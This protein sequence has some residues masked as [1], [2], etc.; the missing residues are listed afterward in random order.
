MNKNGGGEEE[1]AVQL[2]FNWGSPIGRSVSHTMGWTL[3]KTFVVTMKMSIIMEVHKRVWG[4]FLDPRV[5]NFF[6]IRERNRDEQI[7]TSRYPLSSSR[8]RTNPFVNQPRIHSPEGFRRQFHPTTTNETHQIVL[9]MGRRQGVRV[10]SLCERILVHSRLNELT[11][12]VG[13]RE[14]KQNALDKRHQVFYPTMHRHAIC[15]CFVVCPGTI[16][17]NCPAIQILGN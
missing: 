11:L 4:G 7:I 16:L 6:R 5:F 12:F 1:A 14:S 17:N 2:T 3:A 13:F 10:G 15:F 9:K 8:A